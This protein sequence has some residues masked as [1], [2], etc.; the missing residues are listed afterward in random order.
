MSEIRSEKAILARQARFKL[1]NM[2]NEK[3]PESE[4]DIGQLSEKLAKMMLES[5]I[6]LDANSRLVHYSNEDYER[7]GDSKKGSGGKKVPGK[8]AVIDMGSKEDL[9]VGGISSPRL[10]ESEDEAKV[11]AAEM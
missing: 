1:Y 4:G 7:S 11:F 3:W 6:Y 5:G 9:V 8:W 10:F 2:A